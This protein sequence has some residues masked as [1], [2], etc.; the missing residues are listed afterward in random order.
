MTLSII[1][2]FTNNYNS[3]YISAKAHWNHL[4]VPRAYN[5]P[6]LG[7]LMQALVRR[8]EVSNL[9]TPARRPIY[10]S[11]M[12]THCGMPNCM[13]KGTEATESVRWSGQVFLPHPFQFYG[14]LCRCWV[15]EQ[16]RLI[17]VEGHQGSLN[18]SAS[19]TEKKQAHCCIREIGCRN[20]GLTTPRKY[21]RFNA[22]R[23]E[24][25]QAA[26]IT[27]VLTAALQLGL[28]LSISDPD[29]SCWICS[30]I[31]HLCKGNIGTAPNL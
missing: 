23:K 9:N 5:L 16:Q 7:K 21:T 15:E 6:T 31:L 18:T 13:P 27:T 12:A 24:M 2:S 3:T 26:F 20:E 29:F 30:K 10:S 17:K 14:F 19:T 28:L 1:Y 11:K 25:E 4:F 8:K 22:P